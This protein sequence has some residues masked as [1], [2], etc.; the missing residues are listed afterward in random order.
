[1]SN[2]SSSDFDFIVVVDA[3]L[4]GFWFTLVLVLGCDVGVIT[5]ETVEDDVG[6]MLVD[7]AVAGERVSEP[8]ISSISRDGLWIVEVS[9]VDVPEVDCWTELSDWLC[10]ESP[11]LDCSCCSSTSA[12]SKSYKNIKPLETYYELYQLYHCLCCLIRKW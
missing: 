9:D 10:E 5:A 4:T 1:M 6:F 12:T 11:P 7:D 3:E 8:F 2:F